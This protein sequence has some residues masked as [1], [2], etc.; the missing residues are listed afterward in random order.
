MPQLF[1]GQVARLDVVYGE[2]AGMGESIACRI[3]GFSG[4]DVMLAL[5]TRPAQELAQGFPAYLLLESDG[6]NLQAVRGELGVP[7][8]EEVVLRL[9]DDIR[10]GQRRVFSRAPLELPARLRSTDGGTEWETRTLDISAG[11]VGVAREGVD[12]GDGTLKL[13]IQVADHEVAAEV[14]VM[15]VTPSELGLRFEEIERHDRLLL[16]SLA[17]AYHRR[18]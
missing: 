5:D 17:L 1:E 11:G 16:A 18:V 4:P 12:P 14:R 3:I 9:I 8:G 6:G 7:A 15:R 13:T 10:L 2:R